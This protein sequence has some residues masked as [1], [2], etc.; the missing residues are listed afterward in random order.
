V[1]EITVPCVRA[2]ALVEKFSNLLLISSLISDVDNC[3]VAPK[4]SL[5]AN[6]LA[7]N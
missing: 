3:I 1:T 4:F 2:S 5:L 7:L 6:Y